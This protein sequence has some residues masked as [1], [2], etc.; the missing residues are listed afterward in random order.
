MDADDFRNNW[1][2]AQCEWDA[3][4]R[5]ANAALKRWRDGGGSVTRHQTL[6]RNFANIK[7]HCAEGGFEREGFEN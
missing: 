2:L 5:H 7:N 3:I 1:R 6:Q 4:A